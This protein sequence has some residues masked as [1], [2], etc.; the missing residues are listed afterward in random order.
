MNGLHRNGVSPFLRN[1]FPIR[2]HVI[3]ILLFAV[4]DNRSRTAQARVAILIL[5]A[6]WRLHFWGRDVSVKL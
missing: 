6:G 5:V 2:V 1:L 4:L 3:H